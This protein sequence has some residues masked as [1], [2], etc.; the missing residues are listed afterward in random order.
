[1]CIFHAHGLVEALR[2]DSQLGK[3]DLMPPVALS[4]VAML[5][6]PC[7]FTMRRRSN[8]SLICSCVKG[9]GGGLPFSSM[10]MGSSN[11]EGSLLN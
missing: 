3:P 11:V 7:H 4:S 5:S 9:S 2:E 8:I 10:A 6:P 1:M